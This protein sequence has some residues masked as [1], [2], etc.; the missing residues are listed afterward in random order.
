VAVIDSGVNYVHE[1]RL[2]R[3]TSI[4]AAVVL[5]SPARQNRC[6]RLATKVDQPQAAVSCFDA[7]D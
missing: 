1:E 7:S 4:A 6:V 5:N 3:R 2:D